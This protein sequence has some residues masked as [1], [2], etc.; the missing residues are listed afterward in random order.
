[1]LKNLLGEI[2]KILVSPVLYILVLALAG[3]GFIFYGVLLLLGEG[4]A[5]ITLGVLL[6]IYTVALCRSVSGG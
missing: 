1:M 3:T 2:G 5:F 4:V 6:M